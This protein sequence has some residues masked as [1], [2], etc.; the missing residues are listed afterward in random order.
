[1]AT[2]SLPELSNK[3]NSYLFL[4]TLWSRL[5]FCSLIALTASLER[6]PS[7]S[8]RSL[9]PIFLRNPANA[10]VSASLRSFCSSSLVWIS[11]A[12]CLSSSARSFSYL[13]RETYCSDVYSLKDLIYLSKSVTFCLPISISV[14]TREM[15]L[16]TELKWDSPP[17]PSD[18]DANSFWRRAISFERSLMSRSNESYPRFTEKMFLC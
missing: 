12:I 10:C 18:K 2:L 1:M 3:L 4:S 13:L 9:N 14:S 8:L 17:S 15:S 7:Y 5:F 11:V 6:E 16:T